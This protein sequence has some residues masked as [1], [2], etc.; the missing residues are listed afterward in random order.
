MARPDFSLD[1][2]FLGDMF[3]QELNRKLTVWQVQKVLFD[4][5]TGLGQ[6]AEQAHTKLDALFTTFAAEWAVYVLTGSSAIITAIQNDAT[7][8][9]LDTDV[10]GTTIRQRL[11]NRLG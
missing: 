8:P 6:T 9:W 3:Q 5:A 1:T 10:G 4:V 2:A 11:I 7:I